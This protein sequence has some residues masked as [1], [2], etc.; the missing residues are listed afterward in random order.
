MIERHVTFTVFPEKPKQFERF[1]I[2]QY[3]PAMSKMAGFVDAN[4]IQEMQHHDQYQM[5]IC[6]ESA[7]A[8]DSWRDSVTHNALSSIL[9]TFYNSITV[10]ICNRIA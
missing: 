4:L 5:K 1:F 8:S 7:E 10:V 6:F 9:K 2:D 3:R